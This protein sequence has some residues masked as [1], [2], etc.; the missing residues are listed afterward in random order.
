MLQKLKVLAVSCIA[1]ILLGCAASQA[2]LTGQPVN[3]SDVQP[4]PAK[5]ILFNFDVSLENNYMYNGQKNSVEQWTRYAENLVEKI[6]ALGVK[7]GFNIKY[8]KFGSPEK[9]PKEV[10]HI[11]SFIEESGNL[12]GSSLVD[13]Y[14][15]AGVLQKIPVAEL[16]RI[17]YKQVSNYKYNF[18]GWD[19]FINQKLHSSDYTKNCLD[20]HA[21][22]QIEQLRKTGIIK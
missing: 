20:A 2:K 1:V 17:T 18:V 21:N 19:C 15:S 9:L 16:N 11:V 5:K 12:Y 6:E 8:E 4:I 3:F 22:F 14:W 13:V 7:A 10:T